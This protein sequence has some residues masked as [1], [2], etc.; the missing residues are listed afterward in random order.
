MLTRN[1]Q[2]TNK[3][4]NFTAASGGH[5]RALPTEDPN[6][7]KARV[8]LGKTNLDHGFDQVGP[9]GPP[10]IIRLVPVARIQ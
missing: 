1:V 5:F 8:M 2:F 7:E 4:S 10:V 9:D 6:E 3:A